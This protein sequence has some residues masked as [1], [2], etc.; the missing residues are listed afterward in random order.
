MSGDPRLRVLQFVEGGGRYGAAVSV[1]NLTAALQHRDLEV[2]FAVFKGKP[3]GATVEE[4]GIQV[5]QVRARK[6]YDFRGIAHMAKILRQNRIDVL[7]T[8]LSKATIIGSVAAR[9]A[10]VPV[11]ATVHGMNKKY[12]YMMANRIITVSNAAKQYLVDQGVPAAKV[13]AVYNGIAADAFAVRPGKAE[14]RKQIG[15]QEDDLLVGTVSRAER[16]KGIFECVA[17]VAQLSTELPN[18]RY[19]FVGDGQYLEELRAFAV[20]K[21][22]ADRVRFCGFQEN[23][24]P[25]LSAMDVYLFPT[26]QEAF[27]ISLLEAMACQLPIITTKIGGVPEI[28]DQ[29]CARFVPVDSSEAIAASVLDFQKDPSQ[30]DEIARKGYLRFR[31]KFT[32]EAS[33]QQVESLYRELIAS[34]VPSRGRVA[35]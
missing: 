12:T 2:Q 10:R 25:W 16:S 21:G 35:L 15:Y 5:H 14:A 17:A 33:A 34:Y 6:R 9:L 28:L 30:R 24:A 19:A 27:G 20:Q 31:D 23:I 13:E 29:T 3:L 18:L 26:K 22:V 11:V 7:H 1:L 8:H 32:M 4:M